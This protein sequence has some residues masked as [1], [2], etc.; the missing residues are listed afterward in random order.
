[1]N[2]GKSKFF[3]LGNSLAIDFVNTDIVVDGERVDLL[4][5]PE[6]IFDWL[7]EAG[8]MS[9]KSATLSGGARSRALR[10]ALSYRSLLR[11]G[12]AA[13]VDGKVLP[14][15][16]V[17]RTNAYLTRRESATRLVEDGTS[18]R[19]A[20]DVRFATEESLMVPVAQSLA[21]LLVEGEL[22]RLRKCKNPEC[23]LYFYDTSKS[24]TRTWCSLDMC[25][26]K[27]RMAASRGRR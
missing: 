25:G 19:L 17:P 24:G 6:S 4:P 16:L 2:T 7:H 5:R 11:A 12:L 20:T 26:N 3:W 15:Q 21:K 13:R 1:M 27:L 10:M 23:V 14:P 18:F 9:A 22:V 8:F